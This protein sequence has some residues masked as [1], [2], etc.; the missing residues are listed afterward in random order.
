MTE[1]SISKKVFNGVYLPYLDDDHR[2]LIFYGGGG[3]G[4]SFFIAQRFVKRM[5]ERD[6]CN[7]LVLRQVARTNRDS[8]FALMR[9]VISTWGVDGLFKVHKG[10]LRITC[11]NGNEMV[12]AGLDDPEKLKSITFA[13]GELTDVWIEEASETKPEG[14]EQVNLRLRGGT[15][16]KQVVISFNPIDINHWLKARFFDRKDKNVS[17]L[18]TTYKDNQFIDAEYREQLEAYAVLDPYYYAVYCLGQWGVYGKT[19]FRAA[20][21]Q[22]RL[23]QLTAP[24]AV[25]EFTYDY[26]GMRIRD[27]RFTEREDGC[28]CIYKQPQKDEAYAAGGDNAGYGSDWF[29]GQVVDRD[30]VQAATLRQCFDEDEYARQMYCLGMYYNKAVLAVETN[31]STH[32]VRELER[33]GY[34]RLYVRERVDTYTHRPTESYGFV[35][36]GKTRPIILAELVAHARDHIDC[37]NDKTTLE[38]M[39]TFVRNEKGRPEASVGAHDDCIMALA[40]ALHAREQMVQDVQTPEHNTD[41]WTADMWEDYHNADADGKAYLLAKWGKKQ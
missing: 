18:H 27:I 20:E 12:F 8:T 11:V 23:D 33:L 25:G 26:D 36:N 30:G 29:V 19:I 1:V 32:P 14:L 21:V 35:T 2:F 17:I 39:L 34:E 31:Y 41:N 22:K 3:S 4:K 40:I 15:S 16:K 24:V 5:L 10:E 6:K 13:K 38:E 37:I 28:V 7:V 9:S